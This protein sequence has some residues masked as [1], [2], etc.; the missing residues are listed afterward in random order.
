ML[1]SPTIIM[2]LV[3][4]WALSIGVVGFKAYEM[5]ETNRGNADK[6]A[7][8]VATQ[9]ADSDRVVLEDK[10][11]AQ[12]TAA[13]M[14]SVAMGRALEVEQAKNHTV[15]ITIVKW[16]PTYV[17]ALAD[18]RC[19]VPAGFV[20]LFDA[21]FSNTI[22][23]PI[24]APA[25]GNVGD[26]VDRPSGV[27]LSTVSSAIAENAGIAHEWETKARGLRKRVEL[28]ETTYEQLRST[29]HVCQ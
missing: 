18:S 4:A 23:D 16:V 11:A 10:L 12:Q 6:A 25:G 28:L 17:T 22:P 13:R 14:N 3:I 19:I 21:S 9:K 2:A 24:A 7:T 8:L 1:P 15:T 29:V 26:I 5:G 20:Q 27:P